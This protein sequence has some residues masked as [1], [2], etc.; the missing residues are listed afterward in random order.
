MITINKDFLR[1]GEPGELL[2]VLDRV[3]A[4]SQ[5]ELLSLNKNLLERVDKLERDNQDLAERLDRHNL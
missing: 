3:S 1:E 2:Q 4:L 5:E